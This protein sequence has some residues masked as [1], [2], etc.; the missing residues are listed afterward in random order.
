M[1]YQEKVVSCDFGGRKLEIRTGKYAK[2]ASGSVMVRYGDTIVLV[3]AVAPMEEKE[4]ADFFPLTVDYV[5]KFYAAGKIPGG[6]FKREA[7]PTEKATLS[8]RIIDRPIRPLFPE[9]YL[10]ETH[11]VAT[12]LSVD[13]DNEPDY[14]GAIGASAALTLS[15]IP[16]AG[17]IAAC[18]VG[19]VNGQLILNP[20]KAQREQ[21]DLEI[22]VAG[23]KH[24]VCMV[25]GG[26]QEVPESECLDAIYFGH[27]QIQNVI[28]LQEEFARQLGIKKR[29]VPELQLDKN[30][31][32]EIRTAIWPAMEKAFSISNKLD[33]YG[34]L[35]QIKKSLKEK[36]IHADTP[37]A[38]HH[39]RMIERIFELLK[40]QYARSFT[41]QRKK[42]IDGRGYSDIRPN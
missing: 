36:Y 16:F 14:L 33:R 40:Y 5:E 6:Y 30:L 10:C 11:V 3:T 28:A 15:D 7:K 21:S 27:Q 29:V 9:S 42:R 24:A 17:P 2:Q 35:D 37:N 20:T 26:A 4:G 32:K 18:R 8:A 41:I 31:E 13:E 34:A 19:R 23:T 1:N 38:D 22:L 12:I 25:E 39:W